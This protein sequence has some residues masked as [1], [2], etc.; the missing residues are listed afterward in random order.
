MVLNKME[1]RK[2]FFFFFLSFVLFRGG[3]VECI[4]LTLKINYRKGEDAADLALDA[5]AHTLLTTSIEKHR[6]RRR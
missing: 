3:S 5:S 2:L 4:V 1:V 6:R